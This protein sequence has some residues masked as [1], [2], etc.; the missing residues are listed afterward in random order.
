M[1]VGGRI[2]ELGIVFGIFRECCGEGSLARS[3]LLRRNEELPSM[4]YAYLEYH[5]AAARTDQTLSHVFAPNCQHSNVVLIWF[6]CS[7]GFI[8]DPA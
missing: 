1:G 7:T 2:G 6:A 8:W 5:L 3:Y 4:V